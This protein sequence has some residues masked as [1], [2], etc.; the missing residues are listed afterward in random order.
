MRHASAIPD[1]AGL[2]IQDKK[3]SS[4]GVAGTGQVAICGL[5]SNAVTVRTALSTVTVCGSAGERMASEQSVLRMVRP[6]QFA[7]T[8]FT[9]S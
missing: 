3:G 4:A 7:L 1:Q 2:P 5:A 6:R 9:V 8:E